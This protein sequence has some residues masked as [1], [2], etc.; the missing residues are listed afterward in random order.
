MVITDYT[1]VHSGVYQF[2]VYT[3]ILD[4]D[5]LYIQILKEGKLDKEYVYNAMAFEEQD[6]SNI[7]RKIIPLTEQVVVDEPEPNIVS[8]RL[9]IIKQLANG[10]R[11]P[12][13]NYTKFQGKVYAYGFKDKEH[14]IL[15]AYDYK[16]LYDVIIKSSDVFGRSNNTI[17]YSGAGLLRPHYE[18][19]RPSELVVSHGID[20]LIADDGKKVTF[21][22]FNGDTFYANNVYMYDINVTNVKK[23]S[24]GVVYA[25]PL[26]IHQ[27]F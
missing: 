12:Y 5:T 16:Y 7:K 24:E 20:T 18:A 23:N 14:I 10:S 27:Q 21:V 22:D 13:E 17:I 15:S 8:K 2:E 19:D 4:G 9:L 26:I 11:I 1:M 3:D 6:S 25:F